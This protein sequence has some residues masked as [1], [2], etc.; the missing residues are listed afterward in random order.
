MSNILKIYENMKFDIHSSPEELELRQEQ[1]K[2]I[3][4]AFNGEITLEE[5]LSNDNIEG[6]C[7][8]NMHCQ[9]SDC[10]E[11]DINGDCKKCWERSLDEILKDAVRDIVKRTNRLL[12]KES[13]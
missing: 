2:L 8:I 11:C 13:D 1:Y 12:N 10:E 5:F 4:K 3:K 9:C 7:P 6:T